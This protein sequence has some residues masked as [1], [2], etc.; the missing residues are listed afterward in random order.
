MICIQ[1][2]SDDTVTLTARVVNIICIHSNSNDAAT[3]AAR[4]FDMICIQSN[5]NDAVTLT[6]RVVDI[7]CIQSN[8]NDAVT[9]TARVVDIICTH[10]NNNDAVTLTARVVDIIC[11]QSNSVALHRNCISLSSTLYVLPICK[12]RYFSYKCLHVTNNVWAWIQILAVLSI[13]LSTAH[14]CISIV[15]IIQSLTNV[16]G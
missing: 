5:S 10:S 12:H 8:S 3:L 15:Q 11:I 4:V 13:T 6:A 9:L 1:N 2:N 7:I 14:I 16:L